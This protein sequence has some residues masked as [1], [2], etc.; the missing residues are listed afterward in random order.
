M[1]R[2]HLK[3]PKEL[4]DPAMSITNS[5]EA[6]AYL[7]EL[8]NYFVEL[9]NA[10]DRAESIVRTNL[11]WWAGYFDHETRLRVERLFNCQ[12]PMLGEAADAEPSPNTILLLGAALEKKGDFDGKK[13]T[14]I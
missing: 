2:Y 10:P 5:E 7:K 8:V 9:G 1:E 3:E 4:Y 14:G 13:P 12:H 11:S 6:D